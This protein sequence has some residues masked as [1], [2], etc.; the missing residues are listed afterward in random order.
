MHIKI[1]ALCYSGKWI[2]VL[3]HACDTEA[4]A[5]RYMLAEAVKDGKVHAIVVPYDFKGM[6]Q[7]PAK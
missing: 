7:L 2:E 1:E 4:D 6:I 5:K 3:G